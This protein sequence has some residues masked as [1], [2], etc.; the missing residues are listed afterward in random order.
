[1]LKF[2]INFFISYS[3]I[4]RPL[5]IKLKFRLLDFPFIDAFVAS[6]DI[7]SGVKATEYI[8]QQIKNSDYFIILGTNNYHM[9]NWTEQEVGVAWAY[10][11]KIISLRDNENVKIHGFGE[12]FQIKKLSDFYN[13]AIS[14]FLL[15]LYGQF[16]S[17]NDFLDYMLEKELLSSNSYARS[18]TI[19][20]ITESLTKTLNKR[21]TMFVLNAFIK[22]NQVS[23]SFWNVKVS[24]FYKNNSGLLDL[25]VHEQYKNSLKQFIEPNNE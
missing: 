5:A 14:K 3:D 12:E 7:P 22:N 8:R 21:Q 11:V 16:K 24:D 10:D 6:E 17:V 20:S 18:N 1:M 9:S 4:D 19:K 25:S 13:R 15:D 23:A 2:K